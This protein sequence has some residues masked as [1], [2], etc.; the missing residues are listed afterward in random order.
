MHFGKYLH[1]VDTHTVGEATRIIVSGL[2]VLKGKTVMEKKQDMAANYDWIR[3][4]QI[5]EPRGHLNMFGAL[6]VEPCHPEADYGVIFTDGGGYLNMCGHG[7][8]GVSTMLV[9]LGYIP[10]K[11]PYTTVTLEAP[12][13][14]I[15]VKVN[16]EKGRVK[17][18]SLINVPAFVFKQDCTV[19]LPNIGPV[20]FDIAF[21]GSFFAL[22]PASQLKCKLQPENLKE[23]LYQALDLRRIINETIPVKHPTL[24][25]NTV[26]LVEVYDS[27]DIAN[28]DTKNVVAFGNAN[29]DRSPC[30]TGT[31]AKLALMYAEGKIGLHEVFV[32]ESI[33]GTTFEGEVLEET[34]VQGI[35]AIVP[36]ITGSAYI[37]GLNQLVVDE[38][39][40]FKHGFFLQS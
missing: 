33:L 5:F 34:T 22:V 18:V 27:A 24:P 1:V 17:S 23:L 11:E 39:D 4:V 25:I 12:A 6:L 9:E 31:C 21:G 8:I 3:R 2:P 26:D 32:H 37:T 29:I 40:P 36:Q 35:K 7:T 20:T 19:D 16:V 30:G 14:L 15:R 28:A 38:R 10:K 13:G